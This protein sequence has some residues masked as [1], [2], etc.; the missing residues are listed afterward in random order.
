M[1]CCGLSAPAGGR[2]LRHIRH[3]VLLT[4]SVRSQT[5]T[6]LS[7]CGLVPPGFKTDCGTRCA[8]CSIGSWKLAVTKS[9]YTHPIGAPLQQHRKCYAVAR[10]LSVAVSDCKPR[11]GCPRLLLLLT[12]L[13]AC[14]LMADQSGWPCVGSV[15]AISRPGVHSLPQLHLVVQ[16]WLLAARKTVPCFGQALP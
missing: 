14:R 11:T 15:S 13:P 16:H 12:S 7:R 5:G 8:Q 4:S 1:L 9:G 2:N 3:C 10:W 6:I